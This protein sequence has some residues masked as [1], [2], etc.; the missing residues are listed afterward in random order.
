LTPIKTTYVE[1]Q[2]N[3]VGFSDKMPDW[4]GWVGGVCN[5]EY[6]GG[7]L[8]ECEDCQLAYG[9]PET[10]KKWQAQKPPTG[11]PIGP[12]QKALVINIEYQLPPD[13]ECE[14]A[15][16]S[17]MWQ[18]PHLCLPKEV[19]EKGAEMDFWK[20]CQ[21]DSFN[22]AVCRTEWEGE[23]FCNCMD[24]EVSVGN[25]TQPSGPSLA[26]P[27]PVMPHPSPRPSPSH[28]SPRPSPLPTQSHSSACSKAAYGQCGGKGYVGDTC[29]PAGMWCER[30]TEWW[31]H[32]MPCDVKWDASCPIALGQMQETRLPKVGLGQTFLV[33]K[34]VVHTWRNQ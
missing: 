4:Y 28:L 17:W 27:R 20:F 18:T 14:H 25:G 8:Q 7:V 26:P 10:V 16:F 29:C 32:C 23:I 6:D 11:A 5:Y 1:S 30:L 13:F 22:T 15:V 2:R 34:G 19:H 31:S 12:K 3:G 21:K 9:G 24:A 33:P